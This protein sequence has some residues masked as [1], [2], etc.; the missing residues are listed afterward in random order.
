MVGHS[1]VVINLHSCGG[2]LQEVKLY[3]ALKKCCHDN[4]EHDEP[5]VSQ[6]CC[7]LSSIFVSDD[8]DHQVADTVYL[9]DSPSTVAMLF[10]RNILDEAN[11]ELSESIQ[12]RGPPRAI[13]RVTQHCTFLFYG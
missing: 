5:S 8:D 11:L 12:Y 13:D 2:E 6:H 10:G 3:T 1:F 4:E 9:N 7:D